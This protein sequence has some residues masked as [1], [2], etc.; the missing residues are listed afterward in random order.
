M[1]YMYEYKGH[2]Y[3]IS[4]HPTKKNIYFCVMEDPFSETYHAV[5]LEAPSVNALKNKINRQYKKF[6]KEGITNESSIEK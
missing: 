4:K 3:N 5:A 1:A 2:L 6:K